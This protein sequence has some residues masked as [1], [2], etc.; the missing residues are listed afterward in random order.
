MV[1]ALR[2]VS[3]QGN[4]Q[5]SSRRVL[6]DRTRNIREYRIGI[7]TD[8]TNRTYYDDQNYGHHDGVFSDVLTGI[9]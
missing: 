5:Q 1:V 2:P 3:F 8:Q 6:L 9:F 4:L 7:A